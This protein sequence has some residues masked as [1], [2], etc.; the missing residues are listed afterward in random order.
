VLLPIQLD[1]PPNGD[2][3]AALYKRI[4]NKFGSLVSNHHHHHNHKLITISNLDLS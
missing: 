1:T 4:V 2:L 3:P